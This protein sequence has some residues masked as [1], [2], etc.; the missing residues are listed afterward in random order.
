MIN[1]HLIFF[2]LFNFITTFSK[3]QAPLLV[4][5]D[6]FT[7][8]YDSLV[9]PGNFVFRIAV[10]AD[11]IMAFN[12]CNAPYV[13]FIDKAGLV[14]E[15]LKLPYEGCVRNMEFD[16]FDNLLLMD[17]EE[18]NIFKY[19]RKTKRFETIP[20]TKPEDWYKPINHFYSFFEISSIPTF[21]NNPDYIQDFYYTRFPYSYNLWLNYNDGYI[22]QFAYN[23]V[24][25]IGNRK[26][27]LA[28]RRSDIWFSERLT[29]K[30][31]PLL[32][33]LEKET[34]V[35]Y[36][37]S[38]NLILEDFRNHSLDIYQC[39]QGHDEAVQLD[40]A[41]NKKQ[42]KVWGVSQFSKKEITFSVWRVE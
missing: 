24:R 15:K 21:Y 36:D 22:Y 12:S 18:K 41:T 32:I 10:D 25:K 35:Y 42:E 40:F 2:F 30:C 8:N 13:F 5:S 31:K 7:L 37:R 17:N 38:L 6:L 1:K 29:N 26:T 28:L 23:F 33:N 14:I 39:A 11:E 27:Y 16:E 34:A 19:V 3:S 20:Y 9:S 4:K